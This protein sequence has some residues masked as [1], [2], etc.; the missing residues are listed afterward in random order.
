MSNSQS[1]DIIKLKSNLY[2]NKK[3]KRGMIMEIFKELM[4]Y[5]F[6]IGIALGILSNMITDVKSQINSLYNELDQFYELVEELYIKIRFY[7]LDI[8]K[9]VNEIEQEENIIKFIPNYFRYAICIKNYD[10]IEALIVITYLDKINRKYNFISNKYINIFSMLFINI[11]SLFLFIILLIGIPSTF[12]SFVSEIISR[13]ITITDNVIIIYLY[14]ALLVITVL[15]Y[16]IFISPKLVRVFTDKILNK[17]Y[18][19]DLE[20]DYKKVLDD[21]VEKYKNLKDEKYNLHL[22]LEQKKSEGE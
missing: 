2:H 19:K 1:N 15:F 9:Y 18:D 14:M 16:V 20:E 17:N 5:K 3:N 10:S 13:E 7:N 8:K 4:D 6:L 11:L 22:N 21:F 12:I